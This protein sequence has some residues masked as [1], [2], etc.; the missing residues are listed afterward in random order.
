MPISSPIII[1]VALV[2][3]IFPFLSKRTRYE[4]SLQ[5]FEEFWD[6][7]CNGKFALVDKINDDRSMKNSISFHSSFDKNWIWTKAHWAT[8]ISLVT[9]FFSPEKL[10]WQHF[11]SIICILYVQH[12]H[13]VNQKRLCKVERALEVI[14]RTQGQNMN[15]LMKTV[16]RHDDILREAKEQGLDVGTILQ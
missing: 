9:A 12:V 13:S 10:N 1:G 7:V 5:L 4:S 16:N 15:F 8:A 11:V 6:N 14:T 3:S 2:L